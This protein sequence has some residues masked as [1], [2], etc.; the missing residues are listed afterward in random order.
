MKHIHTLNE[1]QRHAL[2]TAPNPKKKITVDADLLHGAIGIATESGELLD[3][4]KKHLFYGRKL[5]D[6][7]LR[8]E[9]GD[10][11]WYL[12]ILCRATNTDMSIIA[13]INIEKLRL[14]Y[15]DKFDQ[16]RAINRNL[17]SERKIL[18]GG[19]S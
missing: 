18:E 8:E 16:E 11:M 4:I 6:T 3:A 10:V 7:N 2:R 5:D 9:I 1:Y 14:R 12:A 17:K 19:V 15:P 13:S